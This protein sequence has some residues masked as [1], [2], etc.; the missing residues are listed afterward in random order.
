MR[1]NPLVRAVVQVFPDGLRGPN[2][3]RSGH[4]FRLGEHHGFANG[5]DSEIRVLALRRETS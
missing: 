5:G 3:W 2:E 4:A 1:K